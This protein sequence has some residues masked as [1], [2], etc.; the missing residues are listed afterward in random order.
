MATPKIVQQQLDAAEA[1]L[2][3]SM[4]SPNLEIVTDA[5]QILAPTEPPAQPVA[6][7]APPAENWEQKYRTVQGMYSAEVPALRAQAKTQESEIIA[8][9]EQ[10]KAL[11]TAVQAKPEPQKPVPHDPKDIESY[12]ADMIDMVNR[13]VQRALE[14]F[15][16]HIQD[17]AGRMEARVASVESALSG[18]SKKTE[19]TLESQFWTLLESLVPDYKEV[20]ADDAWLAWLGEVDPVYQVPRQAAL[21]AAFNRGDAKAVAAIFNTYKASLKAKPQPRSQLAN[22][23]SPSNSGGAQ[24][25]AQAPAKPMISQAFVSKFYTD[26]AKGRYRGREEEARRIESEIN[27]A[28]REGRIV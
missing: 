3:A 22:Q 8:L 27:L 25:P 9:R 17:V 4:Q 7:P 21:D 14:Q 11:T 18:V 16:V 5:S 23:V 15:Q 2:A 20:N 19:S 10:V 6:P 12:G 28:A 1:Q 13:Y 24:A 26:E